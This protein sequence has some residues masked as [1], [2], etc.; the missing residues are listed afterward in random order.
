MRSRESTLRASKRLMA[1]AAAI[2]AL[3]APA[4]AQ[5]PANQISNSQSPGVQILGV[6]PAGAIVVPLVA[7]EPQSHGVSANGTFVVKVALNVQSGIPAGTPIY[8]SFSAFVFDSSFSGSAL[9]GGS[10]PLSGHQAVVT[11]SVPYKWLVAS[12]KDK[13]TLGLSFSASYQS[14]NGGF[15]YGQSGDLTRTIALPANGATTKLSFSS[16]L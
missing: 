16:S 6:A 12:T 5:S 3:I 8:V 10:T 15:D 7:V 2:A 14:S 11:L 1:A 4:T 13:V 9:V